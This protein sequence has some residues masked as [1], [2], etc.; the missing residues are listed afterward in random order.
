MPE[1]IIGS[2]NQ[3]LMV[4]TPSGAVPIC[5]YSGANLYTLRTDSTGALATTATVSVGSVT[6]V[7]GSQSYIYGASG[8]DWY[9]LIVDSGAGGGTL[10][11][12]ASVTVDKVFIASGAN[13]GSVYIKDGAYVNV[14]PSGTF[15]TTGSVNQAVSPWIIL[16]SVNVDNASNIGSLGLQNIM[17]SI[18][19]LT[20]PWVTLGSAQITNTF[21]PISGAIT[22]DNLS[23][24]GS[25]TLQNTK[26]FVPSGNT[27]I[28]SGNNW[29]GVGSVYG[30][31]GYM[32]GSVNLQ[33]GGYV[34]I[35][36]SGTTGIPVSGVFSVTTGSE[37]WIKGGSISVYNMV[38]GS[39]VY[40]P[41]VNVTT[42]S[43]IFN[44]V[45]GS[46]V[47]M[48]AVSVT[49]GSEQW[50]KN[51]NEIGVYAGSSVWQGTSPWIGLG[52]TQITNTVIQVS[53]NVTISN[54]NYIYVKPSGTFYTTGSINLQTGGFMSVIASGTLGLPISGVVTVTN[55]ATAGSLATQGVI[56]SVQL[57]TTYF[58]GSVWQGTNPW[59]VTGS[60][61]AVQNT[62]SPSFK[63]A[64]ATASGTYT[65]IWEV[66]AG[67]K[68]E[69]QGWK[70]S[71]HLPGYIS[72]LC[73][74]TSLVKISD[75][76]LNYG[77]GATIEKTFSTSLIPA[78]SSIN[79]GFSSTVA[80]SASVTIY[81][82][83]IV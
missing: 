45:A 63:Q 15:Y 71:T 33:N 24:A 70:I 27:F 62:G 65:Q 18:Y 29:A 42:G 36:A 43:E 72:M 82:R 75:Y 80:G 56:G 32:T 19:Q 2:P 66:T 1:M 10:R 54:D 7:T 20:N 51:W 35:I 11:T 59:I 69:V 28:V 22:V 41:A 57:T 61:L 77:S 16:G 83:E 74:G 76:Y 30:A 23:T 49:T 73:S 67:N 60:V 9:P 12:T 39:I 25:L 58:P 46:I 68:V 3:N 81:G 79:L 37:S 78:G 4:V 17:G 14:I 52:S 40:M 34:S 13:I 64:T 31:G 8:T 6:A 55:L 44:M 21:I 26:A 47:Y 53:G 50:I 5:G 48:P 38:A